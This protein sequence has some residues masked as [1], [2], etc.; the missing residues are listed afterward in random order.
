MS[1]S[2][3]TQFLID[4]T[5]GHRKDKFAADSEAVLAA[6]GLDE[7]LQAAIR[8]HD[9]GTLWLAGAHPMALMYY[10]RS[11]GW[12]NDRYYAC[13]AQA[14]LRKSAPADA[15]PPAGPGQPRKRRSSSRHAP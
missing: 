2:T 9:V 14:E 8:S 3:L 10:A 7:G 1:A 4:I 13:I 11:L 6:S 15:V 5:R 12:D